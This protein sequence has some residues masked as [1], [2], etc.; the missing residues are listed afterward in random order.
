MIK[1]LPSRAKVKK[2][3]A[4]IAFDFT[5]MRPGCVLLQTVYGGYVSNGQNPASDFPAEHWL[6]APTP[7]LGL[8]TIDTEEQY[9]NIVDNYEEMRARHAAKAAAQTPRAPSGDGGAR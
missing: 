9:K 2:P 7:D 5:S 3:Y 4:A 8:Y 1:E 6:L